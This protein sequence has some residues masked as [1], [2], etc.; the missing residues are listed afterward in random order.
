MNRRK[1]P[2]AFEAP[3]QKRKSCFTHI[4]DPLPVGKGFFR[5]AVLYLPEAA[6]CPRRKPYTIPGPG[7]I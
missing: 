5:P 7:V 4:I 1:L 2:R 6:G 3:C